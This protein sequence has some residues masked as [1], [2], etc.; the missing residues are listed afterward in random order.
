MQVSLKHQRV[1]FFTSLYSVASQNKVCVQQVDFYIANS[2]GHAVLRPAWYG[3]RENG[4]VVS[5][6]V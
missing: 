2:S 5:N 3:G 1:Y 6:L 4:F